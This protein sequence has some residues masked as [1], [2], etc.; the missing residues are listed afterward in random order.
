MALSTTLC[1]T[2]WLRQFMNELRCGQKK[3]R[4]WCDNQS[5]IKLAESDAY[6]P[7]SKHIDIR[8]HRIREHIAAGDVEVKFAPTKEMVADSLTK[9]VTKEITKFC[10][11]NM[12]L[13]ATNFA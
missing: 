6:R 3:A 5:A 8:Y 12:G 10:R 7:R 4:I 13:K 11:E 9:P 2:M 1:E